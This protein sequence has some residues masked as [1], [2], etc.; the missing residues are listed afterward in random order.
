LL[1]VCKAEIMVLKIEHF[2]SAAVALFIAVLIYGLIT[3]YLYY[4][5]FINVDRKED[6]KRWL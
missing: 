1:V 4:N 2:G 3:G 6:L 5:I